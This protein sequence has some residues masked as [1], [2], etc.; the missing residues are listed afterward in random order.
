M[1]SVNSKDDAASSSCSTA[2]PPSTLDEDN[3]RAYYVN[4]SSTTQI[5]FIYSGTQTRGTCTN[6]PPEVGLECRRGGIQGNKLRSPCPT[7]GSSGDASMNFAKA[8]GTTACF[9]TNSSD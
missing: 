2:T 9:L 8:V 5:Q 6:N 3:G 4:A 7:D 1:A